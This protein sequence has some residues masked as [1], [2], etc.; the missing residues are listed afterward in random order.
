MKIGI[1][2]WGIGGADL[3]LRIRKI[4]T[5]DFIY[6][7]DTGYTPYG[8]VSKDELKNRVEHVISFLRNK[9][10]DKIFVACNAA[11][12]V[13]EESENLKGVIQSGVKEVLRNNLNRIGLV[14]GERTVESCI[15]KNTLQEIGVEV[16]QIIAQPLSALIEKGI[17]HGEELESTI[18][19]IFSNFEKESHILLACTHYIAVKEAIL[20][21]LPNVQLLDPID[22]LIEEINDTFKELEGDNRIDFFT[23]GNT[24][25]MIYSLK[26]VYQIESNN[27]N[28][29]SL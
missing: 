16:N 7:S 26:K 15:Y 21:Y 8:K 27:I 4:S 19:E 9:G 23:T 14:G 22:F 12:T 11:S 25:E 6:F 5:V 1:L 29:A 13:I 10:C 2:D 18:Q 24:D 17:V 20:S 3:M 28:I